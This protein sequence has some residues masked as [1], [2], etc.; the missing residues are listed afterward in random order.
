MA[1]TVATKRWTGQLFLTTSTG[2]GPVPCHRFSIQGPN[3]GRVLPFPCGSGPAATKVGGML[4]SEPTRARQMNGSPFLKKSRAQLVPVFD[5]DTLKKNLL[6]VKTMLRTHTAHRTDDP[7]ESVDDYHLTGPWEYSE[8]MVAH[9]NSELSAQTL[10]PAILRG[11][12]EHVTR[13]SLC[14]ADRKTVQKTW[15]VER[16]KTSVQPRGCYLKLHAPLLGKPPTAFIHTS[17][18]QSFCSSAPS[19]HLHQFCVDWRSHQRH[20]CSVVTT[21]CAPTHF[22]FLDATASLETKGRCQGSRGL[23]PSTMPRKVMFGGF[24]PKWRAHNRD[25]LTCVGS[26]VRAACPPE[27]FLAADLSSGL[28]SRQ[29]F[30]WSAVVSVSSPSRS[31]LNG[32]TPFSLFS[33]STRRGACSASPARCRSMSVPVVWVLPGKYAKSMVPTH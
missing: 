33:T 4:G 7:L 24:R 30:C 25:K 1:P 8:D 26:S 28:K 19:S 17:Q 23:S 6:F 16:K 31:S 9:G 18:K 5:S 14:T 21:L 22:K 32:L 11:N 20:P 3:R 15:T 2:N 13:R 10:P 27:F 29:T 12:H